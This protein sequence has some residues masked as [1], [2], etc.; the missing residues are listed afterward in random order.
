VGVPVPDG[1]ADSLH[2]TAGA[3]G[4]THSS[5]AVD[6]IDASVAFYRDAF[7]CKLVFEA[8]DMA[9]LIQSVAGLPEVRCDLA[10]LE[11]P[12]GTHLLELIAFRNPA[13]PVRSDPP[14]GHVEFAVA[15]LGRAIAAVEALGARPVG[16]VTEFPE[17]PSVYYREPGGSVF[18][19]TEYT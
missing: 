9:E 18:E 10:I 6:D 14:A 16:Q 11:V 17:G 5:L 13:A 3:T 4:C 7:A 2:G 12:G 19:L 8:R 1:A 15:R